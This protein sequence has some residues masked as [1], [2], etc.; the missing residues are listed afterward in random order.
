MLLDCAER[1]LRAG[2]VKARIHALVIAAHGVR[3]AA[4]VPQADRQRRIAVVHAEADRLMVDDC[5]G[6]VRL[7]Q[8]LRLL[9]GRLVAQARIAALAFGAGER[10]R[11]LVV[12]LALHLL[13]C[14]R[15]LA[16]LGQVE[17]VLA[18][19]DRLVVAGLALL[20]RLAGDR[21]RQW[22]RRWRTRVDA[23]AL[24]AHLVGGA[25]L[26][27]GADDAAAGVAVR[28]RRALVFGNAAVAAWTS[29]LHSVH[30]SLA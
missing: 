22:R 27:G 7:A 29:A 23:L 13:G 8:R 1:V 24:H 25:V 18:D 19:A 4:G 15:Q 21:R 6:A 2:H 5:A 26:V 3:R 30:H 28:Q 11:A 9:G 10:A 16:V 14:A 17:A 12:R 20:K